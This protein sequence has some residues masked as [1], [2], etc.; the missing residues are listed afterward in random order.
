M[1]DQVPAIPEG[2]AERTAFWTRHIEELAQL[3]L[4]APALKRS[5]RCAFTTTAGP[6]SS[7]YR[8]LMLFG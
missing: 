1:T 7:V 6:L 4:F 2:G 5:L 8:V 3:P